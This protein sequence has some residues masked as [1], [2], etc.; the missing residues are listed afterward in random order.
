MRVKSGQGK[1]G[2]GRV[3]LADEGSSV[4]QVGSTG[5]D[6]EA[7]EKWPPVAGW[8]MEVVEGS[9]LPWGV[10]GTGCMQG[11]ELVKYLQTN[12]HQP[13]NKVLQAATDKKAP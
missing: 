8:V 2:E 4:G 9:P 6:M 1:T 11:V 13:V 3:L 5:V 12:I 7:G 10:W